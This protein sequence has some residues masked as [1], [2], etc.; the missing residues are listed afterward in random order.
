MRGGRKEGRSVRREERWDEGK[1]DC[2]GRREITKK[3]GN[4]CRSKEIKS[5]ELATELREK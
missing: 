2:R 3:T 1:V 4:E 5:R